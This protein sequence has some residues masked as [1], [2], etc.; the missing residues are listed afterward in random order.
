MTPPERDWQGIRLEVAAHWEDELYEIMDN[1]ERTRELLELLC[2][3]RND[4][5]MEVI[6]DMRKDAIEVLLKRHPVEFARF[7]I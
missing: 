5:A 4:E 3:R 1:D 7:V 2:H 6:A